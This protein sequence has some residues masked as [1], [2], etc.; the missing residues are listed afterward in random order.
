M[1]TMSVTTTEDNFSIP[2]DTYGKI[3]NDTSMKKYQVIEQETSSN[4]ESSSIMGSPDIGYSDSYIDQSLYSYNIKEAQ[5][6]KEEV[7]ELEKVMQKL[8]ITPQHS[9]I[10]FG[11]TDR[12]PSL[13]TQ[14]EIT[15]RNL[16]GQ[17]ASLKNEQDIKSHTDEYYANDANKSPDS[18][19]LQRTRLQKDSREKIIKRRSDMRHSIKL[20]L[21]EVYD[22]YRSSRMEVLTAV[23][24]YG[25][26]D[27][28]GMDSVES[29]DT[30]VGSSFSR[31]YTASTEYAKILTSPSICKSC[32]NGSK[33]SHCGSGCSSRHG[34]KIETFKADRNRPMSAFVSRNNNNAN[35]SFSFNQEYPHSAQAQS[36]EDGAFSYPYNYNHSGSSSGNN[37]GADSERAVYKNSR[38]S[39]NSS[40]GAVGIAVKRNY[41]RPARNS[42]K[43]SY[44]NSAYVTDSSYAPKD[45]HIKLS[46][47]AA[48]DIKYKDLVGQKGAD[49]WKSLFDQKPAKTKQQKEDHEKESDFAY[50]TS[51]LFKSN[52]VNSSNAK[53]KSSAQNCFYNKPIVMFFSDYD[54]STFKL[55]NYIRFTNLYS[56]YSE[57]ATFVYVHIEHSFERTLSLIAGTGILALSEKVPAGFPVNSKSAIM[58]LVYKY[59]IKSTPRLVI[60]DRLDRSNVLLSTDDLSNVDIKQLANKNNRYSW[61]KNMIWK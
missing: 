29:L 56:K 35:I 9:P 12:K 55:D 45:M 25:H 11:F 47:N 32:S 57:D 60:L 42:V 36:C 13:D 53:I 2:S 20:N 7:F 31:P 33:I 10:K 4:S 50:I 18:L 16:E 40:C 59:Q 54:Q 6:K 14:R 28:T 39:R 51:S 22:D 38:N 34:R 46:M 58:D 15:I 21:D 23:G 37:C 43:Y 3:S 19:K 30:A 8:H 48:S 17:R 27:H 5:Y 1:H 26:S 52:L 49:G 41:E 44:R 61:I 24:G